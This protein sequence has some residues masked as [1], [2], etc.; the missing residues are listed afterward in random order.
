[1]SHCNLSPTLMLDGIRLSISLEDVVDL[2]SYGSFVGSLLFIFNID[3]LNISY[4]I[5][6]FNKFIIALFVA[7]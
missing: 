4:F 7:Y 3:C 6:V 1:M 5:N 2:K